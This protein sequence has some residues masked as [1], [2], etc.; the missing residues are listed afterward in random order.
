MAKIKN[1]IGKFTI[2][3]EFRNNLK[4]NYG[5]VAMARIWKGNPE[6]RSSPFEF[7]IIVD[8]KGSHHLDQE[9]TVIGYV[10][11]GISVAKKINQL[12]TDGSEWPI[13]D[14]YMTATVIE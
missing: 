7:Y 3:S 2:P 11:K 12:E 6:K 4:H 14:V 1:R 5:A 8:P 9:H 10:T 13:H